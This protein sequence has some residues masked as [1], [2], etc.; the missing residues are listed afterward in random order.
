MSGGSPRSTDVKPVDDCS[1][2]TAMPYEIEGKKFVPLSFSQQQM[3]YV[4][5]FQS[6]TIAY[7]QPVAWR[8]SGRPD[9]EALERS[10]N[11]VIQRHEALRT[12][13][14]QAEGNPVQCVHESLPLTLEVVD[15]RV[16]PEAEREARTQ[17]VV[18]DE[19][20]YP[21]DLAADLLLRA[22]LLQ[23]D[24]EDYVFIVVVHHI[25]CD[26]WSMGILIRE[27]A[28]L[29]RHF[30]V[31]GALLLKEP[32]VQYSDFSASQREDLRGEKLETQL[33]YWKENL[34]AAAAV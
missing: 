17:T 4:C 25:V 21:F 24:D 23:T 7:N 20:R 9:V 2:L 32:P 8:L 14:P 15:L 13:F 11:A 10:L 1:P 31:G 19:A 30:A 18:L 29:Y 16:F 28:H 26:G 34:R 3:W 12:T 5:Q 33:A 22:S 27:L 6:G